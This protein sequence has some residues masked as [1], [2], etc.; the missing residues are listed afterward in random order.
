MAAYQKRG[1]KTP[2][3]ARGRYS[4]HPGFEL[5]LDNWN[6]TTRRAWDAYGAT[7]FFCLVMSG[8]MY[9]L[10]PKTRV[11]GALP[12]GAI[13][14]LHYRTRQTAISM[15]SPDL[16][17]KT[18]PHSFVVFVLQILDAYRYVYRHVYGHLYRHL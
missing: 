18:T 4:K 14:D 2:P 6:L 16:K 7:L 8:D 10:H 13:G 15:E 9:Y 5:V 12:S 3:T 17:G 11:A 1:K